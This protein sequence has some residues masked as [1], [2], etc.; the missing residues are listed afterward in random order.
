MRRWRRGEQNVHPFL[1]CGIFELRLVSMEVIPCVR[2]RE[3]SMTGQLMKFEFSQQISKCKQNIYFLV[4]YQKTPLKS[5]EKTIIVRG[6]DQM[7]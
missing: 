7:T 6:D 1:E 4:N 5:P 3:L 2:R